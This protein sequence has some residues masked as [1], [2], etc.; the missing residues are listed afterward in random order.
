MAHSDV[1]HSLGPWT[2]DYQFDFKMG[3][4][5]LSSDVQHLSPTT[6][7]MHALLT[8]HAEANVC[9]KQQSTRTNQPTRPCTPTSYTQHPK[10][11]HPD[12]VANHT[13][14][15]SSSGANMPT[16]N[17]HQEPHNSIRALGK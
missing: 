12:T 3:M 8:H 11:R 6:I 13:T 9:P 17:V 7:G 2:R 1:T 5:C 16:L 10:Q 15:S 4:D 14:A